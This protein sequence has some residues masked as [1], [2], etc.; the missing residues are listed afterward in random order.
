MN[1]KLRADMVRAMDLIANSFNDEDITLT[2]LALGVADEDIKPD[3]SDEYLECYYDDD[4]N[5]AELMNLFLS[6]CSDAFRCGGMYCD[7][8]G[9]RPSHK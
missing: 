3:T 9:S 4:D 8:I 2:W 6:L 7:K 1:A 5:F